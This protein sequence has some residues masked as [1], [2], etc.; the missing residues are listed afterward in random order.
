MVAAALLFVV[1]PRVPP[2]LPLLGGYS[3]G[4]LP[5]LPHGLSGS[6]CSRS[7]RSHISCMHLRRRRSG[8]INAAAA[9]ALSSEENERPWR[10]AQELLHRIASR[11]IAQ[12]LLLLPLYSAQL[13]W[14]SVIELQLP[15]W[16]CRVTPPALH[17]LSTPAD[18]LL[19]VTALAAAFA[20]RKTVASRESEHSPQAVPKLK[21]LEVT[22][23]N[24]KKHSRL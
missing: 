24:L 16:L 23:R 14:V 7:A 21:F 1:P 13:L 12:M 5:S 4:T 19:G 2:M 22:A 18:N 3:T 9:E 20:V 6:S 17:G 8:D 10:L 11:P 15:K